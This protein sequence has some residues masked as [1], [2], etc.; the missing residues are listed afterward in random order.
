MASQSVARH[1]KGLTR[2]IALI[3]LGGC[4]GL[5]GPREHISFSAKMQPKF[6]QGFPG[7]GYELARFVISGESITKWTEALETL[8]TLRK[9]YPP[10]I[11]AAYK[12]QLEIRKKKCPDSAFNIIQQDN[13]SILYEIRTANCPPNPDEHS[14]TR[15]L[16]GSTN[17]FSLIYT[18]KVK[19]LP[20]DKRDEW[21]KYLSGARIVT[22]K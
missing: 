11:E 2:V 16:Y 10:T 4:A 21:I 18:N 5:G 7:Q 6:V 20:A 13:T 19:E 22:D 12:A 8:N 14:L 17:V 3:I 1:W 15:T 9:N